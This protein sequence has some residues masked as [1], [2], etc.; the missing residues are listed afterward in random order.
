MYEELSNIDLLEFKDFLLKEGY[1]IHVAPRY[2][3]KVREYLQSANFMIHSMDHDELRK[4]ITEYVSNLPQSFQ[5]ATIQAA[6]H[7]F[8][9]Y[10]SGHRFSRRLCATEFER[11]FALLDGPHA[12]A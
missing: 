8:Y 1:S 10:I 2:A 7:I 12:K 6:L 11:L 9:Y 5:K 4:S 3:C